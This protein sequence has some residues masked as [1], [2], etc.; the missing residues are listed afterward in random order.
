MALCNI[1][2]KPYERTLTIRYNDDGTKNCAHEL[3]ASYTLDY[4]KKQRAEHRVDMLQPLTQ[5]GK[6]NPDF[7]KVYGT[8]K[9]MKKKDLVDAGM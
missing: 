2:D 4:M 8:Q 6:V 3:P 9:W 1:C 5:R 7:V